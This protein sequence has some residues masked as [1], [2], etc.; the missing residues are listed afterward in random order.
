MSSQKAKLR[1]KEPDYILYKSGTTEI[2]ATIEA[3]AKGENL[4]KALSDAIEK[5]AEPLDIP[6]VFATDGTFLIS[7]HMGDSKELTINSEPLKELL[8]ERAI[9]KF[10]EQGSD[11]I[12]LSEQVRYSR[13]ELIKVFEWANNLL[14]KEGLRSL[15]RF[16]EFANILFLKLINEI[17]EDKEKTREERILAERYCWDAFSK[18]SADMM[19]EY[20]NN[21]VLPHLV[22][23]YND[24]GDVFQETM[25]IKNP[26]TLKE[27]VDKLSELT[28]IN[29]ESEI[30]GDA[31]EYF[32]KQLSTGNDLGEYFTPR[33]IVKLMTKLIDPQYGEKIY[34]PC[35]G[36]GGFLIEGF[37]HIKRL[38]KITPE[39]LEKLKHH[40]VFGIELTNTA[41]IA[42]M[43]MIL[44][45]DGHTN[46][47]Q[48]DSLANPVKEEY[49]VVLTNFPFSQRTDYGHLY[50]LKTD[51][52]N[53][54][55]PK[56]IVDSLIDGGRAG[57]V[58]FQ[59]GLYDKQTI[60]MNFRKW[61]V[62]NCNIKAIIKLHNYVFRPYSGA[63]TSIILLTKGEPTK[64][65]WFFNVENDG[66][67]KTASLKGR[68]PIEENDL[69]LLE[70]I[71]STKEITSNSWIVDIETIKQ[72]DYI[73][74][75]EMYKP[76][77][78]PSFSRFK[79]VPIPNICHI[80]TDSVKPYQGK[81]NYLKTGN[82]IESEIVGYDSVTY[83]NKPSRANIEVEE[84]DILFAK[85]KYANKSLLITPELSD[86][87][88]STGFVVLRVKHIDELL[89]TFLY[90][91]VS[92]EPF[93]ERKDQLAH[94]ATQKAINITDDIPELEIPLPPLEIQDKIVEE[95][96]KL[97]DKITK[98]NELLSLYKE[99]VI[100]DSLFEFINTDSKQLD[101]LIVIGPQNGLYKHKSFYGSGT[102]II[103]IDNIYDGQLFAEDVKRVKLT[104]EELHKYL[105]ENDDIILN[106]VN[107]E[108]FIGKCCVYSGEFPECIF[109][110]NMMRFK[111]DIKQAL[112]KYVVYY[113]TSSWGKQQIHKK[114]KR[115]VNQVSINQSDVKSLKIPLPR[116]SKQEE[117]IQIIDRQLETNNNLEKIKEQLKKEINWKIRKLYD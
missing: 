2:V 23:R 36:T 114:I 6:I 1:G 113:L 43:N 67:K 20:L 18:L 24:T 58:F 15:D 103:R 8:S 108:G 111:V 25:Q 10:I 110:S 39:T 70:E 86:I 29:T 3:K 17:E 21:T 55:F 60:F 37:R 115:S 69:D 64:E 104:D 65:T 35:C 22:E 85:M 28:L 27:I 9:L 78:P 46:I 106:R 56:H 100:D 74:D 59:G 93:L 26:E 41:R 16:V 83:E 38:C 101:E 40:T 51:D 99:S 52:G 73:L 42:K 12:A 112:P 44:A 97:H 62:E 57:V 90:Y 105:L 13:E 88:V 91:I 5:Y 81:R 4:E 61:L 89:P 72:N 79:P 33:H 77:K 84:K 117:I 76:Y 92:S 30:K 50:G 82:L 7:R 98:I 109:E 47:H 66:F 102:P 87:I 31:F 32:L 54:I 80:I 68:P 94:G 53:V 45:G 11:L 75:A 96:D 49:D 107:S 34:D 14:R 19:M 116:L 71:W 63:N 48:A 95:L